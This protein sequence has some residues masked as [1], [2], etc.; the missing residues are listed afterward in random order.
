[1]PTRR[2]LLRQI[3]IA[4]VREA[5]AAA[6]RKTS[7]EI[8]VSVSVFFWGDVERAA[9]RAFDRLGM[10]HTEQRNGVLIFVVPSRRKF[11]VLGDEGIHQRA[12]KDFWRNVA[13]AMSVHFRKADFT[14]GL[15]AGVTTLGDELA[16]HFPRHDGDANQL[17]DDVDLG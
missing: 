15:V 11:A 12:E 10:R 7:A 4:A 2:Q 1:M 9:H 6:E 14:R 17:P 8:R 5:I 16:R 13:D 3:D